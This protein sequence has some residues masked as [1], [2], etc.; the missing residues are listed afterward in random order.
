MTFSLPK[1][2][3]AESEY[4]DAASVSAVLDEDGNF[5]GPQLSAAVA[6]GASEA[7]LAGRWAN[8]LAT[9]SALAPIVQDLGTTILQA[10]AG[11]DGVEADYRR[12][13]MEA[14]DPIAW[15]EED[16][17]RNGSYATILGVQ[18]LDSD[19]DTEGALIARALGDSCLFQVREDTLITAFPIDDPT[20]FDTSPSLAPSRPT[21]PEKVVWHC[22]NVKTTWQR[23]DCLYLT[24]DALA[25]WFLTQAAAGGMPWKTL[26][27]LGTPDAIADFTALI[28][29]CRANGS[30][31]ND[32]TT[33][34][35]IDLM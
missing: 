8:H 22:L 33:L 17:L 9:S 11:W 28:D 13:R 19:V 5:S 34:L 25:H 1:A 12:Q 31:K 15:Y 7:M 18:L 23:G 16:G 35:R 20:A 3:S 27:E 4:E 10:A 32:D 26:W 2:G 24:T 29:G 6:D 30:I 14:G 21:D